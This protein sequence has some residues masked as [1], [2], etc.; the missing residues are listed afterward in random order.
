ML[1]QPIFLYTIALKIIK[2]LFLYPFYTRCLLSLFS[3][4]RTFRKSH[5]IRR[6]GWGRLRF[7]ESD[8]NAVRTSW[9]EKNTSKTE[10]LIGGYIENSFKVLFRGVWTKFIYFG[11][12]LKPGFFFAGKWTFVSLL[13][14]ELR[15]F[16][17]LLIETLLQRKPIH[18]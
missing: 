15:A 12:G 7:K 3:L 9:R 17:G 11:W 8:K 13:V 1:V 16:P 14:L 10:V 18:I 4:Q 2:W 5:Q 6:Y